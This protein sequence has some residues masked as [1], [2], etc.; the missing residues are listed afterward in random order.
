MDKLYQDLKNAEKYPLTSI[1]I[2]N[3]LNVKIY[4]YDNLNNLNNIFEILPK[5]KDAVVLFIRNPQGNVGHW[6]SILRY[7]NTIEFFDSYG[8]KQFAFGFDYER[9]MKGFKY[10]YNSFEFQKNRG[11][12]VTCG[13]HTI[14]RIYCLLNK[15]MN[16]QQYIEFMRE[17]KDHDKSVIFYVS[18]IINKK[19][20]FQY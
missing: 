10:I 12:V 6:A 8:I 1:D 7:N 18:Q 13:F 5:Q 14:W 20:N 15:N 16:L 4:Q 19:I 17:P 11:N 3:I 9:L 2:L